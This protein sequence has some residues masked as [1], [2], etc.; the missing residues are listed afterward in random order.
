M[1]AKLRTVL[2]G[3]G[4]MGQHHWRHLR[5]HPQ[6][7]LVGLCDS[8][9]KPHKYHEAHQEWGLPID[10]NLASLLDRVKPDAVVLA[11]PT[12]LHLQAA[13]A[14]IEGGIAVLVEKPVAAS[15]AEAQELLHLEAQFQVPIAVGHIERFNPVVQALMRELQGKEIF[16]VQI[17]RVGPIP[18]RIDDVGVLTDLSVH[19]IDLIRKITGREI[20]RASAHKSHKIHRK[21]EDN[22]VLAMTLEGELVASIHTDWLT[23]FKKRR[24]EVATAD[25]YYEADLITQQ[26]IESSAYQ[27]NNS[28][29][30]RDCFVAKSEPLAAEIDAFVHFVQTG[31]RGHLASVAD[32]LRTLE[33]IANEQ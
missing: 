26:L 30:R 28:Y 18:P 16:S 20:L 3:L 15:V 19:D 9:P 5:Q 23:P 33:I 2:A 6:V 24:I 17:T 13:K 21:H 12:F 7:E 25:A 27:L 4:F 10:Q 11:L 32:S 8:N 29:V 1:K 14:C 31:E 22:A